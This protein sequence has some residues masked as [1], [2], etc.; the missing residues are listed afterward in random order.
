MTPTVTEGKHETFWAQ[1]ERLNPESYIAHGNC[2]MFVTR[3][4]EHYRDVIALMHSF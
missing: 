3:N 4:A 2:F 1:L